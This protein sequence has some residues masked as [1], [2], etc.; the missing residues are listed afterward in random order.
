MKSKWLIASVLIVVLIGVCAASFFAVWQGV[1]MAQASGLNFVGFTP[2]TASATAT[3]TKNLTVSGPANLNVQNDMGNITVQ[4]GS[5]GQV[6]VKAEKTAWG[7]GDA[8][9]QAAL[10]NLQVIIVQDGNN[11]TIS[12]KQPAE[13]NVLSIGP[14]HGSVKFTIS[15]PK[16]TAATLHSSNGDV[17]LDGIAGNAETACYP[18][19]MALDTHRDGDCG[20]NFFNRGRNSIEA[21]LLIEQQDYKLIAAQSDN[22]IRRAQAS[23][24]ARGHFLQQFV[25]D[26]VPEAV[27]DQLEIVE[28][29]ESNGH[30]P[31]V[32]LRVENGL[33][34]PVLEQAAVWQA[35]QG[36]MVRHETDAV[37]GLPPLNGNSR[38]ALG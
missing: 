5:D 6:N 12:V 36:I 26:I 18:E 3:E 2:Y 7:N 19:F 38:D 21:F 22:R 17:A 10:K 4:A 29:D 28:V 15:V 14:G 31:V 23:H 35:G 32:A 24:H 20:P 11:I 33:R 13:V 30:P 9:A 16:A 1:Q 34:Q 27:V 8:G 25:A 37:L